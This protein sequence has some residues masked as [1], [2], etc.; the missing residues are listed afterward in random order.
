MSSEWAI[1]AAGAIGAMVPM[2][3]EAVRER[4]RRKIE[5]E[6]RAEAAAT[7]HHKLVT[8]VLDAAAV[9]MRLN[10]THQQLVA[11][12]AALHSACARLA[13]DGEPAAAERA[14]D[15]L[16]QQNDTVKLID[17]LLVI[18]AGRPKRG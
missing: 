15:Y 8:D 18:V 9:R 7:A 11:A 14:R 5:R 1:V 6:M 10:T 16:H 2:G 13:L 4:S 17:D 12:E 3:L